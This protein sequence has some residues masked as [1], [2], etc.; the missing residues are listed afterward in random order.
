MRP[1]LMILAA[2]AL[3]AVVAVGLGQ[4]GGGGDPA[5]GPSFDLAQAREQ[6]RGAPPE[7]AALHAQS[8]ELLDGGPRAV[9]RRLRE[10]R[11]HPVVINKWASWCGPCRV[12]FP[13]FQRVAARMGREVAFLGL[14]GKDNRED[15]AAFL[16]EFPLPFP[17]YVDP[18]EEAARELEMAVAYPVTLF[19]DREGRTAFVH[20]GQ[21]RSDAD[22][23]A[24]I[25]RY[26]LD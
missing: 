11:G 4:A 22:L 21:Y 6:L 10:L 14:D 18:R 13:V 8:A 24:D 15:A 25:R 17:S 7:L 19:L 26:L 1:A 2:C 3:A 12:E 16:S 9:E 20:Q 23:E 5:D